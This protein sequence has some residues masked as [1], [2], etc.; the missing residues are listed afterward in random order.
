MHFC[1]ALNWW[2]DLIPAQTQ[3]GFTFNVASPGLSTHAQTNRFWLHQPR[4]TPKRASLSAQYLSSEIRIRPPSIIWNFNSEKY[5]FRRDCRAL[6]F[7]FAPQKLQFGS[8]STIGISREKSGYTLKWVKWNKTDELKT[9]NGK[10]I[11]IFFFGSFVRLSSSS[12]GQATTM[13][14]MIW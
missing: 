1:F 6:S 8:S 14:W 9:F 10:S 11:A 3:R 12:S 5:T 2:C 13:W 7:H 4:T